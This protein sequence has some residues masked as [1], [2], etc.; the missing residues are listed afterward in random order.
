[1]RWSKLKSRTEERFAASL[2]NRVQIF[3]TRYGACTCGRAWL[4]VDGEIV[5]SFCTRAVE[6]T[7]RGEAPA[8]AVPPGHGEFT[9]QDAYAACWAFVHD[10]TIDD[11][12]RDD[13]PLVQALGMLDGRL[14]KRHWQALDPERL[15]PLARVLL[16]VR[17]SAE[18]VALPAALEAGISPPASP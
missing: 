5:A 9:R 18:G 11:V 7:V 16:R 12:L 14:Q 2:A 15:H 13:D 8:R 3:S 6:R 10:L 17:L 4:T 1:M